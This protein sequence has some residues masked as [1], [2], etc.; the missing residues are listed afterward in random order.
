MADGVVSLS[1]NW[2][3]EVDYNL[4]PVAE[5]L[6]LAHENNTDANS[7]Y[8]NSMFVSPETEEITV[9]GNSPALHLG[10][11]NF[12]LDNFGV[13]KAELKAIAKQPSIPEFN[14]PYFQY[15]INRTKDWLGAT[16]KNVETLAEQSASGSHK[17]D[18]V[19]ALS[20]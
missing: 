7:L 18:G 15:D 13:Q 9:A 14:V 17:M 1:V 11:N 2:G 8:G 19:I 12:P 16:L 10:F 5:S 6:D 4:F 20:V 3:K